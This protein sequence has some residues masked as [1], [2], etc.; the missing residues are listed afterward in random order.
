MSWKL[1]SLESSDENI[2]FVEDLSRDFGDGETHD[3]SI[4]VKNLLYPNTADPIFQ[5]L[6]ESKNLREIFDV[7]RSNREDFKKESIIQ[8]LLVACDHVRLNNE[9]NYIKKQTFKY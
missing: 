2:E 4:L 8:L 3:D 9:V 5:K 7:F 6:N 1:F